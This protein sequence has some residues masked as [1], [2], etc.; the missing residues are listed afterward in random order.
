MEL[1]RTADLLEAI[2]EIRDYYGFGGT[3]QRTRFSLTIGAALEL[4]ERAR[5]LNFHL[6]EILD[7]LR[8]WKQQCDASGRPVQPING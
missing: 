2:D 1:R 6:G 7:D 3:R 4:E 5:N 8:A